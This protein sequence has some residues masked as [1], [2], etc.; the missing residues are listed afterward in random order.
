LRK[1]NLIL[2]PEAKRCDWVPIEGGIFEGISKLPK[3]KE[4]GV[5][6]DLMF[7]E[8]YTN[9]QPILGIELAWFGALEKFSFMT[10]G[11]KK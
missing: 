2:H 5:Q 7:N 6:L 8:K 10:S 4:F 1:F 9:L 3:L 11:T